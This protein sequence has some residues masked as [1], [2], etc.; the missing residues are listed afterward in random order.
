MTSTRL[1]VNQMVFFARAVFRKVCSIFN[2]APIAPN[3][4]ARKPGNLPRRPEIDGL[5]AVAVVSVLLY[6]ADVEVFS[7]GFVGVDVFFVISGYLITLILITDFQSGRFSLS[8]FY[9]GRAR[10]LVPALFVMILLSVPLAWLAFPASAMRDF[11][12]SVVA[13]SIFG[14]NVL[15]WRESGYFDTNSSLKPLLHTWSLGVEAQFYLIFPIL[16]LLTWRVLRN[17]ITLG[18]FAL[19][20]ASL[21]V[22][23]WAV[24]VAPGAS[25]YLLPAR[26][27]ELGLGSLTALVALRSSPRSD[28]SLLGEFAGW[29]GFAMVA[30][31]M[32]SFDQFTPFPGISALIP[33][34]G[35]CLV[36]TYAHA[37]SSLGK[38]L[39]ARV[40]VSLGLISYSLY[41][42][43]FPIFSFSKWFLPQGG[44]GALVTLLMLCVSVFL[45][46]LSWKYIETPFRA[47]GSGVSGAQGPVAFALA[48]VLV[49]FGLWGHFSAGFRDSNQG[50]S[51]SELSEIVTDKTFMVIGDSHAD[52][53]RRGLETLTSGKVINLT[54]NGC[55]PLRDV[56]RYD[57]RFAKR[58]CSDSTNAHLDFLLTEDP[59][60]IIV[61]GSMGPV[62]LDGT[63]FG[64]IDDA[65][66][67]GLGVDLITEPELTDRWAV[68]EAG[69]RVTF[70]ELSGLQNAQIIFAIDWPELGIANGCNYE[71]K[72]IHF[73]GFALG[74]LRDSDPRSCHVARDT[75][76]TRADR[77]KALVSEVALEYPA[78]YVFD[79]TSLFCDVKLCRATDS[80]YYSWYRDQDHLSDEGSAYVSRAI[81]RLL[82]GS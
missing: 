25:F 71:P 45:A 78:I 60:A 29:L 14:S 62:Y 79:P 42:Y 28:R 33:T 37:N 21:I 76:D 68:Y 59:E 23:E 26:F 11:S 58:S 57:Y 67:K 44:A 8:T 39:R 5:R 63:G 65:R 66:V 16:L 10:R 13:A 9:R 41:L 31:A 1:P 53:I 77:Y 3:S 36:I 72:S 69:L 34:I 17:R 74:D 2:W 51:R 22:A 4:E 6:H 38:L 46:F 75:Y 56:D 49:S 18:I 52:D 80:Q 15:F 55:I 40:M 81:I 82:D 48:V 70:A 7:G 50:S 24:Q 43:H 12:Q 27:W 30:F 64:P 47:R 20:L 32:L 61:L 19:T 54:S 73:G 35:T